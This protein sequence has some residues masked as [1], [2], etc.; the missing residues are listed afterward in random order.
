MIIKKQRDNL[1]KALL[2]MDGI[3]KVYP[4]EANFIL[5]K[6]EEPKKIYRELIKNRIVVRDRSSVPLCDGCL[7]ITVGTEEENSSL[8]SVL[9]DIFIPNPQSPIPN[10]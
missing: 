1:Q 3:L 10:P 9:S 5:I 7:R 6:V 4:G 2:K 8:L